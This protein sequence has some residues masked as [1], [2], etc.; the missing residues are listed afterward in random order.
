[1]LTSTSRSI[2]SLPTFLSK[3]ELLCCEVLC[4]GDDVSNEAVVLSQNYHHRAVG[5]RTKRHGAHLLHL[6]RLYSDSHPRR[7]GGKFT[8]SLWREEAA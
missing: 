6:V 5:M 2:I 4:H 8:E 7:E 1:M 3:I